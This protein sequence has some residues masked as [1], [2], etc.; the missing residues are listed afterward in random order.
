MVL[1]NFH[2]GKTCHEA[3]QRTGGGVTSANPGD[4]PPK[5]LRFL[6][7]SIT[8]LLKNTSGLEIRRINTAHLTNFTLYPSA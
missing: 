1:R 3:E 6:R 2:G 7:H 5:S 8:P 4:V